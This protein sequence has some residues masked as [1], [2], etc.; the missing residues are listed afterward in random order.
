M[1]I[2]CQVN[3]TID[4]SS[5]YFELNIIY[6]TMTFGSTHDYNHNKLIEFARNIITQSDIDYTFE[7]NDVQ[8][9]N[10]VT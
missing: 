8:M 5:N 4:L 9:I 3:H 6:G 7:S 2:A 1:T 10:I